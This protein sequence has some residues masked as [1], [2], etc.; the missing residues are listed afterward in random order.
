[1][2]LTINKL[3]R[4][5]HAE[6]D[7]RPLTVFIGPNGTN[8]TWTAYALYKALE[9]FART[10]ISA[11]KTTLKYIEQDRS[12]DKSLRALLRPLLNTL[13]Q[14]PP[15]A[16]VEA[17]LDVEEFNPIDTFIEIGAA[18]LQ[19]LLLLRAPNL[20][21]ANAKVTFAFREFASHLI[22]LNV[23]MERPLNRLVVRSVRADSSDA[24]EAVLTGPFSEGSIVHFVGRQ[25]HL[26]L[27]HV[28]VLPAERKGLVATSQLLIGQIE[29]AVAQP[30][31][32]FVRLLQL[33]H[34]MPAP[35]ESERS[36]ALSRLLTKVIGG[37]IAFLPGEAG[38]QLVLRTT[39]G[40]VLPIASASALSRAVAGLSIY[41]QHFV[42]PDD[43][44]VID[45][46]EMNAH[47][48]AQVALIEF[49]AALVNYGVR[50]VLTT[51]SPYIVDHL[52]NL[53][54]AARLSSAAQEEIAPKFALTTAQAFIPSD[55]VAVHAFEEESPDGNV[56]VRDVLDRNSGL[57][58]WSTFG[59]VSDHVSNLYGEILEKSVQTK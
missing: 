48:Q 34:S 23:V 52:N 17:R 59:R 22:A 55:K 4:I 58:D 16:R 15:P 24:T 49:I 20:N 42:G 38:R 45:E 50:V 39:G 36:A 33:A 6:I 31:A 1:M 32:D 27:N 12:D 56:V 26:T 41:L 43:V 5:Q 25:L 9:F 29:Q 44:L 14:D 46:L 2:K 54:E 51:H 10:T 30:L 47:P 8:K 7:I 11:T 35:I 28:V 19:R 57:I 40:T 37:E 21:Q 13:N 3:G 53:M 18:P